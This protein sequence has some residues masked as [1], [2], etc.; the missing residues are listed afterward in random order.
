MKLNLSDHAYTAGIS[1]GLFVGIVIGAGMQ[2]VPNLQTL[3]ELVIMLIA[4]TVMAVFEH[5]EGERRR[6]T[7]KYQGLKLP[8]PL[9]DSRGMN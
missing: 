8:H 3:A 7:P 6:N 2:S 4:L 5:R 9:A 1:C